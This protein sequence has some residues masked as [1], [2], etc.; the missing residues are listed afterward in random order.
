MLNVVRDD[1]HIHESLAVKRGL[2][3]SAK[4]IDSDQ[5]THSARTDLAET[6]CLFS[7]YKRTMRPGD[8]FSY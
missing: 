3:A 1:L 5:L 6:F 4:G 2:N 8:S 7:L